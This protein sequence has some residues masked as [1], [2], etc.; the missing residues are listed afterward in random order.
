MKQLAPEFIALITILRSGGSGNLHAPVLEILRHRQNL[1]GTFADRRRLG[2]KARQLA[3]VQGLLAP[4]PLL[5]KP[6][7]PRVKFAVQ[8]GEECQRRRSQDFGPAAGDGRQDFDAD[9]K[10]VCVHNN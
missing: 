5:Q 10:F 6:K 8:F 3:P 7:P 4:R 1:P 9:G 2:E